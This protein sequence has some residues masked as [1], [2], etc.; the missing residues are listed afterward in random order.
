MPER[1]ALRDRLGPYAIYT[2][3]FNSLWKKEKERRIFDY[4]DLDK[5][6]ES[7]WKNR[8]S[9][10]AEYVISPEKV[11]KIL[12]SCREWKIGFT[13]YIMTHFMKKMGRKLDVGYAL[14]FRKDKNRSMGNQASGLSLK[15]EYNTK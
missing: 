2:K 12:E 14:D 1:K 13:A 9:D 4:S 11:E 3:I 8:E 10:V 7:Y 5:A 6:Y 15:Y